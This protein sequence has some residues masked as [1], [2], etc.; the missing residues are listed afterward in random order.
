V[1][2]DEAEEH[3]QLL[4]RRTRRV[5]VGVDDVLVHAHV[6]LPLKAVEEEEASLHGVC[7]DAPAG[8]TSST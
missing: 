3:A 6:L 5:E 8:V 4:E 2:D 1:L 7:N